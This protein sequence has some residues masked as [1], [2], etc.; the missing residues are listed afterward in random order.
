M[1]KL[2]VLQ[3]LCS[4]FGWQG[5][6][7]HQAIQELKDRCN[8]DLGYFNKGVIRITW[9]ECLKENRI[10]RYTTIFLSVAQRA[11]CFEMK[12]LKLYRT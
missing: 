12:Q 9:Q 3:F 8:S 1:E 10:S 7:L 6:T 2:T 5:G 11:A 4:Q